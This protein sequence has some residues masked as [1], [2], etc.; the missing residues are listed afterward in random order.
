MKVNFEIEGMSRGNGNILSPTPLA[1]SY[2]F[3]CPHCGRVWSRAST[4][5]P[6]M[7][8][9]TPCR[10]CPPYLDDDVPGSL[11]VDW[12]P[13]FMASWSIDVWKWEFEVQLNWELRTCK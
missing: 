12:E 5:Q 10:D 9:H 1:R 3:L 6:F 2:A 4:G 7:A 8:L 13:E 11:F